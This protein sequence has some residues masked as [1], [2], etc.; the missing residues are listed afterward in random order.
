MNEKF[1]SNCL[2]ASIK[3][4]DSQEWNRYIQKATDDLP[5]ETRP[6]IT[7]SLNREIQSYIT[8]CIGKAIPAALHRMMLDQGLESDTWVFAGPF[9]YIAHKREDIDSGNITYQPIFE[10]IPDGKPRLL[11]VKDFSKPVWEN[12]ELFEKYVER[13]AGE[14]S[15]SLYEYLAGKIYNPA[16]DTWHQNNVR[17]DGL[18]LCDD[19]NIDKFLIIH[20]LTIISMLMG[21]YQKCD[22]RMPSLTLEEGT[23]FGKYKKDLGDDYMHIYFVPSKAYKLMFKNDA[24]A[25]REL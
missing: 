7:E 5:L 12:R 21:E 24:L 17:F 6:K 8:Y 22:G 11:K 15:G 23:Y 19:D 18:D 25:V 20:V 10:T 9:Y 4:V 16:D 14:P 1:I 13:L 2:K 3:L